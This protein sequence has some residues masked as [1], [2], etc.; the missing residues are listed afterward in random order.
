MPPPHRDFK[1]R[2]VA[3]PDWWS[4]TEEFFPQGSTS[5]DEPKCTEH[6]MGDL[7]KEEKKARKAEVRPSP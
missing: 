3:D 2:S 6:Q 7:T 1:E 5:G 4:R